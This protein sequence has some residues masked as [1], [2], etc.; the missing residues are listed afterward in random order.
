MT[1][2]PPALTLSAKNWRFYVLTAIPVAALAVAMMLG[3]IAQPQSYHLFA[4]RRAWLG[5][6]NFGDVASNG[7]FLVTGALGLVAC[8]RW[9]P[10]GAR[11]SW[12]V[13]FGG[14][15]LVCAGSAYYHWSPTDQTLVWD[16]LPMTIGFMGLYIALLSEF[17][18]ARLE[19]YLLVPAVLLGIASV[20]Y[21]VFTDDLRFYFG[22]QVLSLAS[23]AA[24]V[25]T[26][27]NSRRQ[28]RYLGAAFV[29]YAIAV[30]CEQLDRP[31][32]ELLNHAIS[33]HTL[34]HLFA[35][36]APFWIYRMLRARG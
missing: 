8:I 25:L 22:V 1:E 18:A 27:R 28:N 14:V 23:V 16:R 36:L 13:F 7:A 24:I 29:C 12:I 34:K 15:V 6:P 10:E 32:F 11:R 31:I 3:P 9:R 2:S 30:A 17:V 5:V 4:D 21:W 20:A 35:A 26:F 19:R 33:G